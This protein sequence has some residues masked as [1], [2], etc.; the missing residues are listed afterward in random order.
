MG[1]AALAAC[2]QR[3]DP[4]VL[5]LGFFAN[6]TH[7]SAMCGV[8][9]GRFARA[10][11][12]TRL[13][14]QLFNAGPAAM[15][16]LLSGSIDLAYVGPTPLLIAWNAARRRSIKLLSGASSGGASL[17]VRAGG[18]IRC[19]MDFAGKSIATAQYGN[20]QD[21]AARKYLADAGLAPTDRGG[22]VELLHI[23]S[24]DILA[25]FQRGRLDAAWVSE[26]WV[27]RLLEQAHGEIL[28]DE[29]DLWPQRRF[30][31]TLLVAR[32]KYLGLVPHVVER[33][34]RAHQAEVQWIK[35][36]VTDA[37]ALVQRSLRTYAGRALSQAAL[38]GAWSRTE[39]TADVLRASIESQASS[40]MALGFMPTDDIHSLF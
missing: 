7:A 9:S 40:A 30:A 27:S 33:F 5:R 26:P 25:Q 8:L 3:E 23:T 17:V 24:A 35:S 34:V 31:S 28:V 20:T 32:E 14:P 19:A 6:I 10:I 38:E 39:F 13:K 36:Q 1:T 22:N 15:E 12:G 4:S 11:E 18:A 29:R 21:L 16:A 2:R 37:Q